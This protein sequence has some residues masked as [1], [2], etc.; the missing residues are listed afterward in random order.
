MYVEEMISIGKAENGF[1]IN[2]RAPYKEDSDSDGC[3]IGP[4]RKEKMFVVKSAEEAAEKVSALLPLLNDKMDADEVFK[5]AFKE[6][7]S[8]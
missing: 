6:E 8:K 5:T 7:A 4:S 3:C 2:V 1:V